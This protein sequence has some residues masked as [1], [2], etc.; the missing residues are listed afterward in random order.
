M[1]KP[2][3]LLAVIIVAGGCSDSSPTSPSSSVVGVIQTTT[4]TVPLLVLPP[5]PAE[6]SELPDTTAIESTVGPVAP[7]SAPPSTLDPVIEQI[8]SGLP[9]PAPTTIALMIPPTPPPP[10]YN[11]PMS[12]P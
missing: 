1:F 11:P 2:H 8:I 3:L 12:T 4:T 5:T 9:M 6:S 7:S 10:I